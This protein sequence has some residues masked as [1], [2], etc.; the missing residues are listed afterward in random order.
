MTFCLITS[1]VNLDRL[2]KAVFQISSLNIIFLFDKF[3]VA[4]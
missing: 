2:D 3:L 1:D 4:R